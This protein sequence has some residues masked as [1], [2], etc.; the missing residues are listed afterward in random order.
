[1]SL[2][3]R[4]LITVQQAAAAIL[5]WSSFGLYDQPESWRTVKQALA[6]VPQPL[7]VQVARQLDESRLAS[8]EWRWP[9]VGALGTPGGSTAYRIATAAEAAVAKSLAGCLHEL[10]PHGSDEEAKPAAPPDR[11]CD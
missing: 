3:D 1:V 4:D 6:I 5:E 9:L 7:L 11:P 8:G 2:L 10:L